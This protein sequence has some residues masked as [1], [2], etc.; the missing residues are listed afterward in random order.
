MALSAADA[1]DRAAQLIALTETLTRRLTDEAAALNEGRSADVI[2]SVEE[3]A[4]LANVY[5]H[6]AA[7][8]R[9]DPALIAE[10]PEAARAALTRATEAFDAVLGRHAR[11]LEAARAV[12]EGLI[13]TI[14]AEVASVRPT[15]AGY[16]PGAA[17][18]AP[19]ATAVA[20]NR[21]A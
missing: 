18:A 1:A 16:G 8:V 12:S 2:A 6:E 17:P 5:R 7:R 21:K 20:L 9:A 3:T 15:G 4:R 19:D 13:R 10:A 11:V 14:A